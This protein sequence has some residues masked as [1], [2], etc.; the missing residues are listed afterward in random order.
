MEKK[1]KAAVK[2]IPGDDNSIPKLS[3]KSLKLPKKKNSS[4]SKT[5]GKSGSVGG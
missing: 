1:S 3:S 4:E 5:Y 2:T